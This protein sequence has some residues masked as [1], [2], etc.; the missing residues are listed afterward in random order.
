MDGVDDTD[1]HEL[2]VDQPDTAGGHD[3]AADG[4]GDDSADPADAAPPGKQ[5]P[6]APAA[7]K[8]RSAR[9]ANPYADPERAMRRWQARIVDDEAG[10]RPAPA[11][12]PGAADQAPS[13]Q[14]AK[15][16]P[17]AA[18][19]GE[20]A[21]AAAAADEVGDSEGHAP[22]SAS[23]GDSD[24][25]PAP[26]STDVRL[27]AAGGRGMLLPVDEALPRGDRELRHDDDG[28]EHPASDDGGAAAGALDEG[29]GDDDEAMGREAPAP[30]PSA[31]AAAENG[32]GGA[33]GLQ[34]AS[35]GDGDAGGGSD[36]GAATGDD[37]EAATRPA[38]AVLRGLLQP[39][40][41]APAQQQQ[42]SLAPDATVTV[43]A[44]LLPDQAPAPAADGAA[45]QRD[46]DD[47]DDDEAGA[48]ALAPR[49][50][51]A[52]RAEF[53]AAL[54]E[55]R[56]SPGASA[57]LDLAGA[58]WGALA[59][60]TAEPAARLC[61]RLRLILE[62]TLAAKL[63]GE[64]RSG[65]RINM[66]R[67]IPYIASQFRKDKIWM[68]RTTPSKR[69]YQ[70]L[71]A[72]DDSRSMAPG[73]TGGGALACEAVA[74][75]C[76]A[77]SRLEVGEIG[78]ASFGEALRLLHPLD[79]PFTDEAG[80]RVLAQF[81]FAQETTRVAGALEGMVA[82]LAA[83]RSSSAALRAAGGGAGGAATCMQLVFLVSDGMLG[84]GQERSRV[85]RAVAE[86][87]ARGQL[88]VLLVVDRKPPPAGGGGGG[89][90]APGS[91]GGGSSESILAMQSISFAGTR[92]VRTSYLDDYPFPY[93]LVMH[94][95]HALPEVLADA[96]R[97][98][99]ELA[100]RASAGGGG[101]AAGRA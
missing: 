3:S 93:Y 64:F 53:E 96:L 52:L 80:A 90:A 35:R 27:D 72:V 98:W 13:Q 73:N 69:T 71:V 21:A 77:L 65:K 66:R 11:P 36:D 38:D 23:A 67:V 60:L 57:R 79:A 74:L 61:E 50:A 44:G 59:A 84:S 41:L 1:T 6:V 97:Q 9:D 30:P 48:S 26:T 88:V 37:E 91:G 12:R 54:L 85:R 2:H 25:A 63:G 68:R 75:L 47:D 76:K 31:A 95:V 4:G 24:M 62:P 34:S 83:A 94:D 45:E 32:D 82:L 16:Q 17:P 58:A 33:A 7:N 20:G 43:H 46:D 78:I 87:T 101:A 70:V 22:T 42:P 92:V 5:P 39:A 89:E 40:T 10:A 8:T 86:A 18:E 19:R 15:A 49:D 29:A 81:S 51:A 100:A 56:A 99:F 55:L 14:A 28:S